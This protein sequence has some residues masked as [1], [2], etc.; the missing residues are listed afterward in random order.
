MKNLVLLLLVALQVSS[1]GAALRGTAL[2]PEG[3]PVYFEKHEIKTDESGMTRFIRVEYSKPDGSVFAS[4]TSDFTKNNTVPDT[5]FEDKRF[6]LKA[7]IQVQDQKV[8]FEEFKNGLSVSKK[9]FD[10]KESMVASQGFDNFIRQNSQVLSSGPIDFSFGVLE[11]KEFYTL[12]A[13]KKPSEKS[14]EIRFGIRASSW[15]IR[16]FANELSVTYDAKNLKLKTFEGQSNLLDDSGKS[17][18]VLINYEWG[19]DR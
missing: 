10:L 6:N 2:N 3:K 13:Y 5:V 12:T 16:L 11:K 8:Q 17:Q 15:L 9:S 4:M 19:E 7:L 1:W 18:K 14:D